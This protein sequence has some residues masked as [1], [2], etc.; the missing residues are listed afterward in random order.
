LGHD[1]DESWQCHDEGGEIELQKEVILA[2]AFVLH[3]LLALSLV[4]PAKA[5]S[6]VNILS[7]TIFIDYNGFCHVVGEVEN[8]G[9]Q[10]IESV[11]ITA[12]FYDSNDIMITSEF[13]YT[14]LKVLLEGRKSPFE[15]I[16]HDTTQSGLVDHY[17]LSVDFSATQA[18]PLGL[19]ILSDSWY[20][21][22]GGWLH[23][24]GEVKNTEYQTATNVKIVATF[25]D[26]VRNV[27]DC[28]S[29]KVHDLAPSQSAPF[30]ILLTM[31]GTVPSVVSYALTAESIQY[32]IIPEL[33][34]IVLLPLFMILASIVIVIKRTTI[35][36]LR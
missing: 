9:A 1:H 8:A 26:D 19:R 36:H 7:H 6:Q 16:L 23:I 17:S 31:T 35:R 30:E 11:K 12:T 2:T 29:S 13:N 21:D 24:T 18:L 28:E 32:A 20:V 22:G 15:I 4:Q 5:T 14:Y 27:L 3:M 10:A 33:S 34:M 25:Y